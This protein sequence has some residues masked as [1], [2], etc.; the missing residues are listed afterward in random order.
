MRGPKCRS[1]NNWKVRT[2]L[3]GYHMPTS[4]RPT[5]Q[6]VVLLLTCSCFRMHYFKIRMFAF[7]AGMATTQLLHKGRGEIKEIEDTLN[8]TER[9]L[10]ETKDIGKN[11][12]LRL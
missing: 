4:T 11:V 3:V 8:R 9:L 12:R 7:P 10:E 5:T 6:S 2:L 1:S